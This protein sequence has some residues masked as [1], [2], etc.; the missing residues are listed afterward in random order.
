VERLEEVLDG[1]QQALSSP[2]RLE[3]PWRHIVRERLS[4]VVDGLT[5]ERTVATDP[6][7]SARAHHLHREREGL[8]ARAAVLAARLE[9][10]GDTEAVRAALQR[11]VLDVRHHGARVTDLLYDAYAMDVGGSE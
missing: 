2:P 5:A 9:D 6:W 4:A 1:L 10:G 11:L 3:Q 8:L 7:L